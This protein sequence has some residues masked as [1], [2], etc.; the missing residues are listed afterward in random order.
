MG[1]GDVPGIPG[2][3][4][5]RP[6]NAV[7]V[8]DTTPGGRFQDPRPA[9]RTTAVPYPPAGF[10][11]YQLIWPRWSF[12]YPGADFSAATVTMTRNAETVPTTLEP[13][14]PNV[15]EPTLVWIYDQRDPNSDA[16]HAKPS[17]DLTYTVNVNNVRLGPATQNFSYH[18]TVFDPDVAS[19]DP[20]PVTVS[21]AS[22]PMTGAVNSYAV[23]RPAFA[24]SF[25][26]RTVQLTS[27]TRTF[28]A[29]SGLE[30]LIASTSPGYDVVQT[31]TVASGAR[32]Y[33]LCS[34]DWPRRDR[35]RASRCPL[36]DSS[37]NPG[38]RLPSTLTSNRRADCGKSCT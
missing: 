15:G 11:P 16:S 26:W 32:S 27:I 10:V 34:L 22:F 31:A 5:R 12:S 7:W 29:E 36:S 2:N 24:T 8:I 28:T 19:V 20:A 21:G 17:G 33:R 9:T 3:Q 37:G 4:A 1:T 23:T 6:A 35:R 14:V 18:V 38:R 13:V 25:E 30:D